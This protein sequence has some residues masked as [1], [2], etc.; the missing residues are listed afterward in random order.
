V[1]PIAGGLNPYHL[2][3]RVW[4]DI[5]RRYDNPTPEEAKVLEPGHPDGTRKLFEV[6]EADR[7]VSFLRRHLT[8]DLMRDLHLFEY[9][10]KGEDLVVSQVSDSDGWRRVKETL[11]ANV[12]MG[13]VPVIKVEDSDF[14]QHRTLYLVHSHDGRDLQLEY[15]EKTLAYIHRLWQREVA[16][17]TVL[18]GKRSLLVYNDRGFSM[19]TLK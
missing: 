11:L 12:G 3:L 9:E 8:E 2:G 17:E 10:A 5:K 1:R 19:K 18:G 7:D 15:A 4:E 6:R 13:S 14:G 16:L